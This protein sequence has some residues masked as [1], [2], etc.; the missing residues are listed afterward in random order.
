MKIDS[1][2]K[3][4]NKKTK[5]PEEIAKKHGVSLAFINAQLKIGMKTE[6][7]H[8]DKE[9]VAREIALDHLLEDPRYY[10]K[11]TKMEKK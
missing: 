8:T 10:T 3:F 11:L 6:K 9:E 2:K 1:F 7:E 4:L 5:S